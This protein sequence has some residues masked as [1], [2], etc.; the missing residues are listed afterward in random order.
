MTV[1][2]ELSRISFPITK[3]MMITDILMIPLRMNKHRNI[4]LMDNQIIMVLMGM[5]VISTQGMKST[6]EPPAMR[7]RKKQTMRWRST[8]HYHLT[9]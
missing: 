1:A 2:R 7:M 6:V 8:R 9:T 3:R 4:Q 5:T